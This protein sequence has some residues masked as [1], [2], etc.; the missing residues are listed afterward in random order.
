M[1]SKTLKED[2]LFIWLLATGALCLALLFNQYRTE[3]LPLTYES[4]AER[5]KSAVTRIEAEVAEVEVSPAAEPEQ[6]LSEF[7]SLDEFSKIVKEKKILILDA[8]PEIFHRLGHIPGALSLPRD[9]FENAYMAL[10]ETLE[11]RKT[12]PVVVYCSGSSCEDSH[13]VKSSLEALGFTQISV[14]K[15]GW[16]EWTQAGKPEETD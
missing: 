9:D 6:S 14:F 13:L 7:V 2:L 3:P 12:Q 11:S 10:K 5:L 4:K 8:R 16:S 15:G 1:N